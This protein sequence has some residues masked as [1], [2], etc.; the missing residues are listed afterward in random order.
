MLVIPAIDL[1]GGRCVRLYQGD[2]NQATVY[3][4]DPI[5]TALRWQR[6]G[7]ER[8]HVV[9]LDGAVSGAGVNTVVIEQ[10]C[11]VL[12][13]PVQVG[14]GIRNVAAIERLL[15]AEVSRV[16]LGTVAYRQPE[17]VA[18][19]CQRFPGRITVGI[20]ARVGKVA[21]QGWTEATE[22]EAIELAKRCARIGVSEIVYTDIARDGTAQGV[23]LDAT[24]ALAR[25][26]ALPIIASGG[27]ASVQDIERLLP[28]ESDGVIGVIVGRALYTGAVRLPEAIRIGKRM[29]ER[30]QEPKG[31]AK[32]HL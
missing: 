1:K 15:S 6:E 11:R 25:A 17:I 10:I 21:V 18:T 28:L 12:T 23:N 8:L 9:D 19:A 7:A 26:V 2:M 22:L 14:G 4:D 24:R 5:A 20:D 27:V 29:E 3:S 30:P 31:P 16:I 13:I 32:R